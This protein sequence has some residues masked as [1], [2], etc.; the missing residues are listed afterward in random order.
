MTI[1]SEAQPKEVAGFPALDISNE[2]WREYIYDGNKKLRVEG[3][4]T[5]LL[6][7]RPDGNDRHRLII[8]DKTKPTT[9]GK[10][11]ERGM[12]VKPGWLAIQW[13]AHDGSHGITF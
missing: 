1:L 11:F 6:E 10:H 12:Y 7:R 13:Q 2:A 8:K 5:L 9:E 4:I 3:A